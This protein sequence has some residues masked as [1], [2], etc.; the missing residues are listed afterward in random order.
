MTRA[1]VTAV[2]TQRVITRRPFVAHQVSWPFDRPA[3]CAMLRR[4]RLGMV[5]SP[6][7]GTTHRPVIAIAPTAEYGAADLATNRITKE[8]TAH[9]LAQDKAVRSGCNPGSTGPS[10]TSA[11]IIVSTPLAGGRRIGRPLR[12]RL[13][14]RGVP[15]HAAPG[16]GASAASPTRE[17]AICERQR[18]QAVLRLEE[19]REP[20]GHAARRSRCPR[21]MSQGPLRWRSMQDSSES[22][23]E[24]CAR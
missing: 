17:R 14:R 19:C 11:V 22:M 12:R 15:R 4:S 20:A 2:M 8:V 16:A 6:I 24:T 3:T 1:I 13:R 5:T 9:V 18:R 7:A 10:E 21:R 23:R